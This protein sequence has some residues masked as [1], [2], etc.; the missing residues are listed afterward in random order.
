MKFL[1]HIPSWLKNKYLLS[2]AVFSVWLIFFDH[3]DLFLQVERTKELKQLEKGK[4]YYSKQIESI[5]KEL[6]ELDANPASLEKIAREK[7]LMKKEG[8]D[9]F[10][11]EDK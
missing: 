3:N 6:R 7:Y 5:R 8:E 9:I 11:I 2:L 10:I 1:Q 4:D